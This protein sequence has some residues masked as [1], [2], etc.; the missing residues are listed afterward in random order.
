[1]IIRFGNKTI[2]IANKYHA[3]Q[4]EIKLNLTEYGRTWRNIGDALYYFRDIEV[5]SAQFYY[6]RELAMTHLLPSFYS[7]VL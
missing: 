7:I 4:L 3:I 5:D 1:M 2:T 6:M